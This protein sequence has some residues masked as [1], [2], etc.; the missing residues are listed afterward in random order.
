MRS[1]TT[2]LEDAASL[3][4][5]EEEGDAV[6]VMGWADALFVVVDAGDR[7]AVE[8]TGR[9]S[10]KSAWR[11]DRRVFVAAVRHG[12]MA[13]ACTLSYCRVVDRS[14]VMAVIGDS[15]REGLL[16]LMVIVCLVESCLSCSFISVPE[17]RR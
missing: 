1:W 3:V 7:T 11:L 6:S 2:G 14:S 13:D 16:C 8:E 5:D 10:I 15:R 4:V 12:A 17:T 9:I